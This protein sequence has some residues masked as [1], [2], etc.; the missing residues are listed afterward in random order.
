VQLKLQS[1]NEKKEKKSVSMDH[2]LP[3]TDICL[4]AWMGGLHENK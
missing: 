1:M 3:R 4:F 2:I